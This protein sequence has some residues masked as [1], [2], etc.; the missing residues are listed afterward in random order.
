MHTGTATTNKDDELLVREE[1]IATLELRPSP[2]GPAPFPKNEGRLRLG[3]DL[4]AREL[5]A[6]HILTPTGNMK[7][8]ASQMQRLLRA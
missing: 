7:W 6:R 5:T 8:P 1:R 4:A 2:D 3:L